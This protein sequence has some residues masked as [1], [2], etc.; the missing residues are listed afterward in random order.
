MR[1]RRGSWE[2]RL[3]SGIL[4]DAGG[5]PYRVWIVV[6][7]GGTEV[8]PS[9]DPDR[10]VEYKWRAS[11]SYVQALVVKFADAYP[12]DGGLRQVVVRVDKRSRPRHWAGDETEVLGSQVWPVKPSFEPRRVSTMTALEAA[13]RSLSFEAMLTEPGSS[14]WQSP[15]GSLEQ[16]A[17][18]LEELHP[19]RPPKKG[20]RLVSG[21]RA[22]EIVGAYR[23]GLVPKPRTDADVTRSDRLARDVRRAGAKLKG[24]LR[25]RT[26]AETMVA[27][28]E[29]EL[30]RAQKKMESDLKGGA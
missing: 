8:V 11:Y 21:E 19:D 26:L 15:T 10:L 5:R 29:R 12:H 22:A 16:A 13:D 17:T 25:R 4:R 18:R 20:W 24:W 30:R 2:R 9:T 7:K 1:V 23:Q 28:C 14:W 27:K 3:T 6:D